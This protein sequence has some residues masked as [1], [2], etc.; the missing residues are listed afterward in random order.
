M[1]RV[2]ILFHSKHTV[3]RAR[4]I[5]WIECKL[6]ELETG[7]RNSKVFAL[8]AKVPAGPLLFLDY[9]VNGFFLARGLANDLP[10]VL[11]LSERAESELEELGLRRG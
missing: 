9:Y 5:A 7:V 2:F 11:A 10:C 3:T 1:T 8:L 6:A 4:S